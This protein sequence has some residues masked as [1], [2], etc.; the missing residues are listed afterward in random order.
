MRLEP[1]IRC[2]VLVVGS[3]IAGCMSAICAAEDGARVCL[4]SAGPLFS[5]SSFFEGT[6]GLGCIA[7][8][9]ETDA[10][11]LVATIMDVG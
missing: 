1:S 7:P 9:G 10:E 6:W 3:G 5:G 8:D 2:D 4:A 11:D